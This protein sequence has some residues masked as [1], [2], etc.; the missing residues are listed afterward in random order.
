MTFVQ[1]TRI[2]PFY[3]FRYIHDITFLSLVIDDT[4]LS[5]VYCKIFT[6]PL[7]TSMSSLSKKKEINR[8]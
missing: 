5:E 8:F 6:I 4:T 1:K 2:I 7:Q 3:S